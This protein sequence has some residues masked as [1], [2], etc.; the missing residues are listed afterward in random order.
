M[1]PGPTTIPVI[2]PVM[3]GR[4][5][6]PTTTERLQA[7]KDGHTWQRDCQM[8]CTEC[9]LL[10]STTIYTARS[11]KSHHIDHETFKHILG[12]VIHFLECP[13]EGCHCLDHEVVADFGWYRSDWRDMA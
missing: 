10:F 1:N 12:T 8:E 2:R 9:H 3:H 5:D 13:R 4:I 6:P 11:L 7:I